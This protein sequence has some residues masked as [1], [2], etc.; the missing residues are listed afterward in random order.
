MTEYKGSVELISGLIPKNGGSFALVHAKDVQMNDGTR[1][2]ELHIPEQ[3]ECKL[4]TV[5]ATENG[6]ILQVKNGKWEAA[7]IAE[8]AV[9]T[10]IDEYISSALGG[11][12]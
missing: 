8:T 3:E 5:T 12:Y 1:L 2:S 10:Y 9:K 11:D 7:A 6:K 4:P